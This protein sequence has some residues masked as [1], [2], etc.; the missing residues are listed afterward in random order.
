MSTVGPTFRLSG[1]LASHDLACNHAGL[2]LA[3]VPLLKTTP[4]G[5]TPR[6]AD[7]VG[8]L[9]T[10]AYGHKFRSEELLPGLQVVARAL[11]ED[12]LGRAMVASLHLKLPKLSGD[13]ATRI[14]AIEQTLAKAG[15]NSAERRDGR[16][17]WTTGGGL[18]NRTQKPQSLRRPRRAQNALGEERLDF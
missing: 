3:G 8:R 2:F 15:F 11:N 6:S 9:L 18:A 7:E 1:A 5:F 13:G 4:K 10:A 17:R 16:G 14:D 12:D